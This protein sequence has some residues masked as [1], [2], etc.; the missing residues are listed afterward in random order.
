MKVGDVFW[1]RSTSWAGSLFNEYEVLGETSRS[2]VLISKDAAGWQRDDP[3]RYGFKL[4]KTMHG[5][6]IGTPE[7][8]ELKRWAMSNRYR[9]S[10]WVSAVGN[11]TVNPTVLKQIAELIDYKEEVK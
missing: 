7:L 5:Y 2:W 9:I 6:E 1:M 10:Q 4:P 3:K 8:A 11:P